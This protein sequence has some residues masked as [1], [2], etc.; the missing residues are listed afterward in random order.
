MYLNVRGR[1][2]QGIVARAEAQSLKQELIEKLS[3]LRDEE[4][5]EV[6]IA[7]AFDT[8]AVNAGPYAEIGP[9]LTLGYG[10]GYRA[11]WAAAQGQAAGPVFE[12]NRR[13]WSGDHCLD[14]ALVPGV[15]FSNVR[16]EAQR[17]SIMDLAPTA[18]ELFGVKAPAYM[19]GR[20]LV[21]GGSE[22]G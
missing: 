15:L 21:G 7:R 1:E 16:I 5:G 4:T 14:P 19:E 17:A 10:V 18:L 3:G 11:S 22:Q 9:D 20:S 13:R 8:S 12:D 6:A 2:A